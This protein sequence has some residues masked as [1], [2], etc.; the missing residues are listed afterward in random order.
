MP[1]PVGPVRLRHGASSEREVRAVPVRFRSRRWRRRPY[2]Q[3]RDRD[4]WPV[5]AD[6]EAVGPGCPSRRGQ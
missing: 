4:V 2:L 6:I 1:V 3:I 5:Y